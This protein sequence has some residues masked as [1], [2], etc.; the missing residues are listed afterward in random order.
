MHRVTDEQVDFILNDIKT[1]GVILEDLQDNL[2]DHMCCIIESE[3][4]ENEDF[5]KFYENILPLFFKKELKELQEETDNLLTFKHYYA[6]KN[7][8]KISGMAS[9]I[10]MLLGAFLKTFH[11]PGAGV[12]IVLGAVLFSLLFLPLMIALKFKDEE[13]TT[14]K[15]VFSLGFILGIGASIGVLFKVMHWP[16]ANVLMIGST[17]AFVFGYVPLYFLTRYRRAEEQFNTTV[18]SIL[19]MASGGMLYAMTMMVGPS[20]NVVGS[21]NASYVFMQ[22]NATAL[23]QANQKLLTSSNIKSKDFHSTS[24]KLFEKLENTK[25]FLISQVDHIAIEEARGLDIMGI[26]DPNNYDIIN[27]HFENGNSEFSLKVIN[28]NVETYNSMVKELFPN[29]KEKVIAIEKLQLDRTILAIVLHELSQIQL[30]VAMNENSYL[31]SI[32]NKN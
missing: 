21:I 32:S 11:L 17:V 31:S 13:K 25:A 23:N 27:H 16:G 14:D 8:L 18:N 6:M 19:M 10:L 24:E 12:M 9:S 29:S 5:Y 28:Q 15:W 20:H 2:L 22:H 7:T 3:M 26:G 1:H 4:P 30:Q